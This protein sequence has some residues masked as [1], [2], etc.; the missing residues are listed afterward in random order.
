MGILVHA[1][2]TPTPLDYG[3][4]QTCTVGVPWPNEVFY[5]ALVAFDANGNRG[6]ISNI[7][8]VYIY[9]AP[10]T[11]TTTT[12]STVA[13]ASG[14]SGNESFLQLSNYVSLSGDGVVVDVREK[15]SHTKVYIATGV[16]CG[17]LI[18]IIAVIA[19]ILVRVRTK[20]SQYNTEARDSYRAYEPT[21]PSAGTGK[22]GSTTANK[23]V[24]SHH[25]DLSNTSKNLS[26]W[27]DSLPRSEAGHS[28][29]TTAHDLSLSNSGDLGGTL[30]RRSSSNT[31]TLTKTNP[32]RHKVLTNG[33]FLNLNMKEGPTNAASVVTNAGLVSSS[34]VS[35]GGS[36][37]GS[38]SSRPT[39]ST[40]DNNSE[41]ESSN[42]GVNTASVVSLRRSNTTLS[43]STRHILSA[44]E[45]VLPPPDAFG[46]GSS[47][48]LNN[49]SGHRGKANY[50]TLGRYPID[51]STAK[52]IIDTYSGNLFSRG[53]HYLSFRERD[54]L[55]AG[56]AG[57]STL[58]S[59]ERLLNA[60]YPNVM[61]VDS[62][63]V[64]PAATPTLYASSSTSPGNVV[65]GWAG[66]LPSNH[67]RS[68]SKKT[69]RT[70]SVV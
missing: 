43:A 64:Y 42:K 3:Q 27:L 12:T 19:V 1:S 31:H 52:A 70:E 53:S 15:S 28:P 35:S 54:P 58:V 51:T 4:Q 36:D 68:Q 69:R 65:D 55:A 16:V 66:H 57:Q 26:N 25:V 20:R 24:H 40:E 30:N 61:D 33:S 10:T 49:A 37:N 9:E 11:T 22:P 8:S 62:L 50:S 44:E 46:N 21:P 60:N 47:A 67:V 2:F 48:N 29:N 59:G 6:P 5:Y 23:N 14:D 32:Y 13:N 18:L 7:I 45:T 38:N 39:T 17:L 41:S 34:G 63:E 56:R